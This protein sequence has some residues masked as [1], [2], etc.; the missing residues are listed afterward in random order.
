MDCY[1]IILQARYISAFQ[2]RAKKNSNPL[3]LNSTLN[4]FDTHS[5][6]SKSKYREIW[7][8]F[9]FKTLDQIPKF[10]QMHQLFLFFSELMAGGRRDGDSHLAFVIVTSQFKLFTMKHNIMDINGPKMYCLPLLCITRCNVWFYRDEYVWHDRQ[11]EEEE[12]IELI[13]RSG[14]SIIINNINS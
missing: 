5:L 8:Q 10:K 2:T 4:P 12:K 11:K 7:L 3:A 6:K 13:R 14:S 1:I 9:H